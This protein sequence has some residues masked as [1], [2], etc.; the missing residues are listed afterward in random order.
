MINSFHPNDIYMSE[1]CRKNT[2]ILH[3]CESSI[4]EILY[5]QSF[6]K[7]MIILT[8]MNS[9]IWN[10]QTNIHDIV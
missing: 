10:D 2:T 6:K 8:T 3:Q 7:K 5:F 4:T 9:A 1:R